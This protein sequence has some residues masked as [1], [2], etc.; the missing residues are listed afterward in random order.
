M[1]VPSLMMPSE[2]RVA[3]NRRFYPHPV[4]RV[5]DGDYT[6]EI[7]HASLAEA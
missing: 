2:M 5:L 3:R 7:D 4:M 6:R 1:I